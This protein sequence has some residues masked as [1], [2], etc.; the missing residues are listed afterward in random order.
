VRQWI[1]WGAGPRASQALVVGA[2]ARALLAAAVLQEAEPSAAELAHR[3][4]SLA[5]EL[6]EIGRQGA[7]LPVISYCPKYFWKTGVASGT[8]SMHQ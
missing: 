2:K 6:D 8:S 5:H 1:A 3:K 4:R 7:A